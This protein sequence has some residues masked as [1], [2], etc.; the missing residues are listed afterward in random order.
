MKLSSSRSGLK[1]SCLR[2]RPPQ[3]VG[4]L[5]DHRARLVGIGPD[6]R[7]DRIQRVEQEVRVDL[8]GERRQPRLHQQL[9]LLH[10]LGLVAG[11]V[12]DLERQRHRE[13]RGHV[14]DH[15][16]QRVRRGP[17]ADAGRTRSPGRGGPASAAGT[18]RR[19]SP[20]G[21]T[22]WKAVRR[23]RGRAEEPADAEIGQRREAPDLLGVRSAIPQ[24]AAQHADGGQQRHGQ[25]LAVEHGRQRNQ[26]AGDQ[27]GHVAAENARQQARF[28]AEVDGL[29]GP[30]AR[31]DARRHARAED[32]GE[33]QRQQQPLVER[34]LLPH[35]HP[36][37]GARAD[38]E[39]G[40][41]APPPPA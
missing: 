29:V 20:A 37:E 25:V 40:Q 7:G 19:R 2:N 32:A 8:A 38:H 21:R 1:F 39:A 13:Q 28:Q 24:Q 34:P 15:G 22:S 16:G 41:R 31:D 6:Q 12:P 36:L 35:Q 26:D 33:A 30:R 5:V 3:D 23:G 27:A 14:D 10:Q 18:P 11:V 17:A 4:E 9:L